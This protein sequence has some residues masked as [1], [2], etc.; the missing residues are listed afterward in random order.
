LRQ[1]GPK[2]LQEVWFYRFGKGPPAQC[3]VDLGDF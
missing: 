2:S 3:T 1:C